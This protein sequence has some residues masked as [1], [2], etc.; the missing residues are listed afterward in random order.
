MNL[1]NVALAQINKYIKIHNF[2]AY[3]APY[4][5]PSN[6]ELNNVGS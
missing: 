5:I 2:N 1:G 6:N 4:K 3:D